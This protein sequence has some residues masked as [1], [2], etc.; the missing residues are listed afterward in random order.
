MVIKRCALSL[1]LVLLDSLTRP[2]CVLW[3]LL[4][5]E[6]G[7]GQVETGSQIEILLWIWCLA[8]RG[9]SEPVGERQNMALEVGGVVAEGGIRRS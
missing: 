1:S 5:L 6:K 8:R 3:G 4:S 7:R 9:P 2:I